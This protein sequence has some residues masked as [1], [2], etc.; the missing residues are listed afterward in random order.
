MPTDFEQ[1]IALWGDFKIWLEHA[2]HV[3]QAAMHVIVGIVLYPIFAKLLKVRWGSPLPL[4]PILGMELINEAID[5]ARY[6]LAGWPYSPMRSLGDVVLTM[7]PIGALVVIFRLW[8]W[9]E[10]PGITE[11]AN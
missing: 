10:E 1:T 6:Y 5:F 4:L 2:A 11:R 3:P 9:H 7:A 8:G